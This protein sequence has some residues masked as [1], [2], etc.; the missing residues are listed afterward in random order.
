[1]RLIDMQNKYKDILKIFHKIQ[2]T[3]P[4]DKL[5]AI[6]S[7]RPTMLQLQQYLITKDKEMKKT[8][9]RVNKAMKETVDL[10]GL[11]EK[12]LHKYLKFLQTKGSAPLERLV[13]VS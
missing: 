11:N 13:P 1:M 9:S 8:Y 10:D 12:I 2:L 7:M 4:D 5:S 6:E 3:A